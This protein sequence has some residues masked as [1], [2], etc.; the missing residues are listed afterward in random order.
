M[1]A[2]DSLGQNRCRRLAER[3]PHPL[4]ADG[5]HTLGSWLGPE[6]QRDDIA[7]PGIAARHPRVRIGQ[8]AAVARA[9]VMIDEPGEPSLPIHH[10]FS[11]GARTVLPHSVHE[12]S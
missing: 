3:T 1:L 5:G 8:D 7:A 2:I 9:A 4:E 11:I 10:G 12:P 6:M